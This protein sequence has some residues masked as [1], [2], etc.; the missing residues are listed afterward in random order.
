MESEIIQWASG[1][2]GGAVLAAFIV[3]GSA[4]WG[5]AMRFCSAR[6]REIEGA[7]QDRIEDLTD[8][9]QRLREDVTRW[10]ERYDGQMRKRINQLEVAEAAKFTNTP[11]VFKAE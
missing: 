4:S 11:H 10:Q 9:V 6:L 8:Q 3:G 2:Q 7:M 1:P 5:I